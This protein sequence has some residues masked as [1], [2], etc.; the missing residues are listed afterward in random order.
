MLNELRSTKDETE[1][2]LLRKAGKLVCVGLFGGSVPIV[3]AMVAMKAVSVLGS[4]VGSLV[5]M[6]ELGR[7]DAVPPR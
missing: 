3:P 2:E 6:H 7:P 4:Y 5:E 1:I